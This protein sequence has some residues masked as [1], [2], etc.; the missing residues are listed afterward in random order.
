MLAS[1]TLHDGAGSSPTDREADADVSFPPEDAEAELGEVS[2]SLASPAGAAS[3]SPDTRQLDGLQDVDVGGGVELGSP[4]PHHHQTDQ[5]KGSLL[6]SDEQKHSTTRGA[7]GPSAYSSAVQHPSDSQRQQ[8]HSYEQQQQRPGS[9]AYDPSVG[10][11]PD[12]PFGAHAPPRAA[13]AAAARV[14]GISV[15]AEEEEERAPG[16]GVPPALLNGAAVASLRRTP[17]P[18]LPEYQVWG[19]GKAVGFGGKALCAGLKVFS[20]M[21]FVGEVFADFFGLYDSKYQY[22]LDAHERHVREIQAE[23][24]ERA[25]ARRAAREEAAEEQAAQDVRREREQRDRQAHQARSQHQQQHLAPESL[26]AESYVVASPSAAT[27]PSAAAAQ[28]PQ[29][30]HEQARPLVAP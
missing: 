20:A 24:Q 1:R 3:A 25:E 7:A 8:H 5:P 12:L 17:A 4:S 15:P 10:Q 22:V 9:L 27:S 16:A 13:S 29:H 21:E 2:L 28:P 18:P 19:R 11:R 26:H 14:P 23:K 6:Q 30:E